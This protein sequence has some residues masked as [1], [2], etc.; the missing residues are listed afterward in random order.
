MEFFADD[1][2]DRRVKILLI[3]FAGLGCISWIYLGNPLGVV[4]ILVLFW[5]QWFFVAKWCL[6]TAWEHHRSPTWAF[7]IGV[8]F[9]LLG[10]FVY[11]IFVKIFKDGNIDY[12]PKDSKFWYNKGVK[13]SESK[14]YEKALLAY[15][16]A[17]TFND[18]DPDIW[19]NK[20]YVLTKLGNCDEAIKAGKTAVELA[21]ND[22]VLWETLRDAYIGCNNQEK[23]DECQ[24]NVLRLKKKFWKL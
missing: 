24:K 13:F 14:E 12:N 9:S 16:Q 5:F 19:N 15:D 7:F 1:G 22:P 18:K 21:P 23:A 11:W 10:L 2:V 4:Y 3:I 17:L 8:M 6:D 20:C